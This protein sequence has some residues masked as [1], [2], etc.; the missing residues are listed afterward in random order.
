MTTTR[1]HEEISIDDLHQVWKKE[2]PW[3]HPHIPLL[4]AVPKKIREEQIEAMIVAPI[5]PGQIL[6][7][8]LVNKNH[9]PF[10]LSWS[11]EMQE[12]GST[13]I[14]K[15]QNLYSGKICYFL[16]NRKQEREEDL[17]EKL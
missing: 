11:N 5:W 16:M 9:Q 6:E 2:L 3:N 15:N 13:Q 4:P 1:V 14:K 10:M 17:K 7:S 12:R 8:K